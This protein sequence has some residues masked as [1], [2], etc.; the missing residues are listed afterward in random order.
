[1][2]NAF[3]LLLAGLVIAVAIWV[4][5]VRDSFAAVVAFVAYGLLLALVWVRIA[6]PDVALTE[7]AIG[8][9]VIGSLLLSATVRFQRAERS[10]AIGPPGKL[11][12]ASATALCIIVAVALTAIV[13]FLPEPPPTLAPAAVAS[14]PATG[15]DNPVA[16][17]LIAYRAVD[18]L[19]EAVVLVLAT[20]GVWSLAPDRL[21]GGLPGQK[22]ILDPGSTLTLLARCLLPVGII[23]G[24]YI[25]WVG[26]Q[27]PGGE[28][29]AS[30]ILGAMW[31]LALM[32]GLVDAPSIGRRWLRA[33]VVVGPIVFMASGFA[34]FVFAG[35]FLAYPT[36][37]T[38]PIIVVI[39][40]MLMVSIASM[41]GLLVVG[42]PRRRKRT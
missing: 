8:S 28:F 18:T 11:L 33:V 41:L 14:L 23:I 4:I 40:V 36:Q 31:I 15:L 16:A 29:Q 12:R 6:A 34:G 24:L 9:G 10:S 27:A 3:D 13:L 21:W 30:A 17:V 22:A 39:E 35:G 42:P 20:L 7:A 38:K 5:S 25:F 19:L 2:G 26:S 32:S 37:F 1:V